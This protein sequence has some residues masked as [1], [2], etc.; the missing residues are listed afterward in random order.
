MYKI[1]SSNTAIPMNNGSVD[2]LVVEI[3]DSLQK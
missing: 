2:V 1:R 3:L